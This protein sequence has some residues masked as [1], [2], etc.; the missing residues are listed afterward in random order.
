[1]VAHKDRF[2]RFGYDIFKWIFEQHQAVLICDNKDNKDTKEPANE[3]ADDIMSIIT[4][5]TARYY[6]KRKYKNELQYCRKIRFYPTA[7]FKILA[8]KCFGATRYLIN[9]AIEG[10]NKKTIDNP[11]NHISLRKSVLKSDK[12]LELPENQKEKWLIDVPCDTKQLAL[13]QLA[14][15]YKTGFT[16]LKNKTISHFNIHILHLLFRLT[17]IKD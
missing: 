15:N 8:E 6:G 10:I 5:F 9:K 13:K 7:K 1:M 12:E 11:T 4:V 2:T 14:S 17:I 16:Q 3:L